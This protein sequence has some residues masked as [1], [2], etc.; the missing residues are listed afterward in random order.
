MSK[1][2]MAMSCVYACSTIGGT[3]KE[4]WK[5]FYEAPQ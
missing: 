5:I 2:L 4:I 1:C 3:P